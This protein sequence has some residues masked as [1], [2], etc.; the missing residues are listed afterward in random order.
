MERQGLSPLPVPFPTFDACP[1]IG[2]HIRALSASPKLRMPLPR[3][4]YIPPPSAW[5]WP[6]HDVGSHRRLPSDGLHT[7]AWRS[8]APSTCP[9]L[10]SSLLHPASSCVIA[11]HWTSRST[12]LRS[13]SDHGETDVTAAS[14]GEGHSPGG[15]AS[16][17]VR[18]GPIAGHAIHSGHYAGHIPAAGDGP[19][20][21]SSTLAVAR[22]L[23]PDRHGPRRAAATQ[24]CL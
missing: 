17:Q 20:R 9:G 1:G 24:S 8:E 5:Q 22:S 4:P 16:G 18:S 14:T 3:H 10:P 13:T 11:F 12:G 15:F 6:G 21:C 2:P 23:C 7:N 19:A